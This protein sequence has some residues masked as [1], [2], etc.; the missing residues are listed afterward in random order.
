MVDAS[1]H[2]LHYWADIFEINFLKSIEKLY[3][4]WN[5]YTFKFVKH[6]W[7]VKDK[8]WN[9]LALLT[10]FLDMSVSCLHINR[11]NLFL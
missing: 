10:E 4:I 3:T 1:Y 11:G 2:F 8:Q 7:D 5:L 9:N 6:N